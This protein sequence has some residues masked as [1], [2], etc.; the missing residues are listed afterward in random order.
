MHTDGPPATARAMLEAALHDG[1]TDNTT[2]VV[3]DVAPEGS[4]A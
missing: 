4:P 2:L 3:V 1:G